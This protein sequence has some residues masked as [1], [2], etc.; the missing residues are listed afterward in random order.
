ISF[1]I[2]HFLSFKAARK[3]RLLHVTVQLPLLPQLRAV[4]RTA[5]GCKFRPQVKEEACSNPNSPRKKESHQ[6]YTAHRLS[7][8]LYQPPD[9]PAPESLLVVPRS[10]LYTQGWE[11]RRL[12]PAGM[13]QAPPV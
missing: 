5:Q 1:F 2:G 10:P 3:G 11:H 12:L 13:P 6:E 9:P 7:P 4:R 8:L